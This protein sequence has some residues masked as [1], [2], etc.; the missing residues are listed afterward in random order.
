MEMMIG[1]GLIVV[2]ATAAG[3][4]AAARKFKEELR[5]YDRYEENMQ[6]WEKH[7]PDKAACPDP[8]E[9]AEEIRWELGYR[10]YV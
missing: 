7:C 10:G 8:Y 3:V 6:L 9:C 2:A 4:I 5:R 1:V